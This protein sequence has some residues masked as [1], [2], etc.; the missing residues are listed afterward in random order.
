[1]ARFL[2]S[3]AVD[4]VTTPFVAQPG[5]QISGAGSVPVI[6]AD[7]RPIM[8]W[9]HDLA[10]GG[11]VRWNAPAFGHVFYVVEGTIA[12]LGESGGR[13]C[14]LIVGHGSEGELVAGPSGATLLHF[15]QTT[16]SPSGSGGSACFV[17][18]DG[19][20]QLH[21]RQGEDAILYA[22]A[23]DDVSQI[24]L[25]RVEFACETKI[26]PHLHSEDE[27]IAV[28]DGELHFGSKTL[29]RGQ[30]VAIPADVAYAFRTGRDGLSFVNFRARHPFIVPVSRGRRGDPI[31]E[32]S[33]ARSAA[34]LP[35]NFSNA[36]GD[37]AMKLS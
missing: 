35:D 14:A 19:L 27:I 26:N 36:I 8:L 12:A 34:S 21:P 33:I 31:S 11:T 6:N 13:N 15:C 16:G 3:D 1:M 18:S 10:A 37:E 28:L 29:R 25:H 4:C 7:D 22:D 2:I 17:G 9:R 23:A 20:Y 32:Q 30:A 5:L 24:W